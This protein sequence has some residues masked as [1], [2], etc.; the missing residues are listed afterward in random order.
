MLST[1]LSWAAL[2][3]IAAGFTLHYNP[4]LLIRWRQ[5]APPIPDTKLS[6][7]KTKRTHLRADGEEKGTSTPA[8]STEAPISKKRKI[9]S[10]PINDT[11]DDTTTEGSKTSIPRDEDGEMNNRAF[12]QQLAKAQTGIKL[13]KNAGTKEKS[14]TVKQGKTFESPSLSAETSSAYADDDMSPV[15]SP[16]SGPVSTAPT[17]RAGDVS[18][19]LEAPA[20]KPTTLRLTDTQEKSKMKQAPKKI[21]E[22]LTKKQ[23]QRQRATEEK[24]RQVAEA[25]RL[26]RQMKDKQMKGA[27]MAEGTSKQTMS[28]SFISTQNA[29][30]KPEQSAPQP[31]ELLDTFDPPENGQAVTTQ[32]LSNITNGANLIA[33]RE[34]QGEKVSA[35]GAS[36][37]ERPEMTRGAGWADEVIDDEQQSQWE[38]KLLQEDQQWQSVPSKKSKKAKKDNDTSSE[39][40]SAQPRRSG[41]SAQPRQNG[42]ANSS[43]NGVKTDT[44]NRFQVGGSDWE[45]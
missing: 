30:K 38:K 39:A 32:P 29:W 31:T 7:K 18:D 13:G 22:A 33:A 2:L 9:V 10:A 42:T 4:Q 17:S 26:Q 41:S 36:T 28:N 6:T 12:A 27:R 20:A 34:Q 15:G 25:D 14:R 5:A 3:A 44:V 43:A 1:V 21:D 24:N 8:S 35:L 40:S 11:V 19:M 16:P 45:A 23:R 37:R